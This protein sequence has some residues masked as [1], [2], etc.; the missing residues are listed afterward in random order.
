MQKNFQMTKFIIF[1]TQRSGST[2]LTKTLD[3]HPQVFAAGELFHTNEKIHHPEWHFPF[4]NYLGKGKARGLL[5]KMNKAL[6]HLS[7]KRRIAKH[8]NA[9]F[10]A[11]S[12]DEAARGFKLMLSQVKTTPYI[13]Q[14]TKQH[15]AKIIVLLRKNI[16]ETALSKYRGRTTKLYHSDD[17]IGKQKIQ[18]PVVEFTDWLGMLD[19]FNNRILEL[20]EGLNRIVI[21]YEDFGNWQQI[22]DNVFGFLNVDKMELPPVLKKVGAS[23]WRQDVENYKELEQA[24]QQ[25]NY[26][27]WLN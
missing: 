18:I 25:T 11:N 9:F 16:F 12:K 17:N 4:I 23:D 2:V 13:W 27:A 15:D 19:G 21:Y 24:V 22:M 10:T 26:A 14:Q 1:T 20:T 5:M 6:N 8:L 7:I 3:E